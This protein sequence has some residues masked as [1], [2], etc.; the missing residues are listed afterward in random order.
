MTLSLEQKTAWGGG[1]LEV[2]GSAVDELD[3][4]CCLQS[5]GVGEI[6]TMIS[7][8]SDAVLVNYRH[9]ISQLEVG[10][11]RFDLRLHSSEVEEVLCVRQCL[12]ELQTISLR[13]S[14]NECHLLCGARSS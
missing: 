9:E 5:V 7:N 11:A 6:D 12:S 13:E 8:P 10:E 2:I 14:W 3:D 4:L 1:G